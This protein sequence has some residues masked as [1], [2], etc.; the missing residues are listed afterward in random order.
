MLLDQRAGGAPNGA[1]TVSIAAS[2]F[3]WIDPTMIPP[4]PWIYG[5]HYVRQFL[6]VTV[7]PGGVGK[8]GLVLVEALAI[9]TGR[10]LLGLVP[11][12]STPYWYWNG[13]DPLEELQRRV[14]AAAMHFGVERH[15]LEGRLF[16]DSG[17]RMPIILAT[18]TR[19]GA[20][21]A[22]PVSELVDGEYERTASACM[23]LWCMRLA[24]AASAPR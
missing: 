14:M 8:S 6:S 13:E 17:R 12:E 3:R 9:A 20:K 4:R 22:R 16:L 24:S 15:Q 7:S 18:Q 21:L 11:A 5:H 10:P 23:S 1:D 2:P 19:D